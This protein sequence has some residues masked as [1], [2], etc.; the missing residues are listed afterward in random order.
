MTAHELEISNAR[1]Q[2][3][4]TRRTLLTLLTL[5]LTRILT[6]ILALISTLILTPTPRAQK[7]CAHDYLSPNPDPNT[8]PSVV[9]LTTPPHASEHYTLARWAT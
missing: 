2:T 9:E 5:I 4:S 3:K 7:A 6:L 1:A 8:R